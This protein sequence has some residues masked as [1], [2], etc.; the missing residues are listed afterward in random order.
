MLA[1]GVMNC[2]GDASFYRHSASRCPAHRTSVPC[3][4]L[5]CSIA[6]C[7]NNAIHT[8]APCPG[9][10]VSAWLFDCSSTLF[11]ATWHFPG[12]ALSMPPCATL[13]SI[14]RPAPLSALPGTCL[15]QELAICRQPMASSS[16]GL[17]L[18][19]APNLIR[20]RPRSTSKPTALPRRPLEIF[21]RH[22]GV[23]PRT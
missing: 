5:Q 15:L 16:P 17:S 9:H 10:H 14:T 19:M 4:V 20:S 6:T 8:P 7:K 23:H 13:C 3:I 11:N 22:H 18:C 21:A 12:S 2:I 1:S